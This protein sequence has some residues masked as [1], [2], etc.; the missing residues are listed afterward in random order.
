MKFNSSHS[1]I[2]LYCGVQLVGT[3]TTHALKLGKPELLHSV[4]I[5][6]NNP[7]NTVLYFKLIREFC[8]SYLI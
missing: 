5:T 2:N 8:L 6:Q 1:C 4:I 3:G 7:M